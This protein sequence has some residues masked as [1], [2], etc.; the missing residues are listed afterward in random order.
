MKKFYLYYLDTTYSQTGKGQINLND[1]CFESY[2]ITQLSSSKKL[3][4]TNE[5]ILSEGYI[6]VVDANNPDNSKILM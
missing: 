5:D 1:D 2:E 4:N 6:F 3:P